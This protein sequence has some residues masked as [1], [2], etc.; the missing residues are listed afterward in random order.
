[1]I[2]LATI[3]CHALHQEMN[4]TNGE[5]YPNT[6]SEEIDSIDEIDSIRLARFRFISLVACCCSRMLV[7][8]QH[9][10]EPHTVLRMPLGM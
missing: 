6:H 3:L 7:N 10:I 1:M 4:G 9:L 2:V 8:T 5:T